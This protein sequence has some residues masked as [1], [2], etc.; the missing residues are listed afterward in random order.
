MKIK[1]KIDEYKDLFNRIE[2]SISNEPTETKFTDFY[3]KFLQVLLSNISENKEDL[4]LLYS[5][6]ID[7]YNNKMSVHLSHASKR[8]KAYYNAGRF[9]GLCDLIKSLGDYDKILEKILKP[10]LDLEIGDIV[11]ILIND[12]LYKTTV[13]KKNKKKIQVKYGNRWFTQDDYLEYIFPN[14][15]KENLYKNRKLNNYGNCDKCAGFRQGKCA[16]GYSVRTYYGFTYR[17]DNTK[18]KVLKGSPREICCK[19]VKKKF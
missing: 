3:S 10:Y 7:K 8:E 11:Y 13:I 15:E 4:L 9:C 2:W 16:Y 18:Y 1:T 5:E 19:N 6:D 17:F 14:E 12:I